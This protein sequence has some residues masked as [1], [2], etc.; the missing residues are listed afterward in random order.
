MIAFPNRV[1][2][3][4]FGAVARCTLPI[5]MKHVSIDPKRITIMDFEPSDAAL[6]PW[7]E[8]GMTFVRNRVTA[9]NLGSL[10]GRHLSAG[11]LLID[12][13]WNID[14]C[15]IVQWCHDRGVLY[16]NTSVE[17]WDPYGGSENKHPTERT[18]YWRHMNLRRMI[19][20]WSEPG[21]TAVIEHGANPG[22]ISHF[23]KHALLDIAQQALA[24]HKFSGAQRGQDRSTRRGAEL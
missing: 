7:I 22:L 12:L 20:R 21:P 16:V 5:F 11:D 3:V 17:L 2:F 13:A 23:T 18:L 1:L 6:K 24:D 9:E 4:G 15:E 8:Q 14:C 10:L 19:S